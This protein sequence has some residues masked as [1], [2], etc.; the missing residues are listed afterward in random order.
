MCNPGVY[1]TNDHLM[2]VRRPSLDE[3]IKELASSFILRM[4]DSRTLQELQFRVNQINDAYREELKGNKLVFQHRLGDQSITLHL[5]PSKLN[6]LLTNPIMTTKI[7]EQREDWRNKQSAYYESNR[8]EWNKYQREYKK[9]KYAEDP[10]YKAKVKAY[11]KAYY[12]KKKS[13]KAK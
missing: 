2:N 1:I 11:Q 7:N 6:Q 5:E 13:E 9:K 8:D 10:D 3:A 4:M 12:L